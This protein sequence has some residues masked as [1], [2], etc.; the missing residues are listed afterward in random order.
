MLKNIMKKSNNPLA[1]FGKFGK[2][3]GSVL[4]FKDSKLR[5]ICNFAI[6]CT[7]KIK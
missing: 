2:L 3:K 6:Y 4:I 1:N 7:M 5:L